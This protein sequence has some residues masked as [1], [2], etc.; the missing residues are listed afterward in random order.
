MFFFL[1]FCW[2]TEPP[3]ASTVPALRGTVSLCEPPEQ[4]RGF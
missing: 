1:L 4:L 2:I 3:K